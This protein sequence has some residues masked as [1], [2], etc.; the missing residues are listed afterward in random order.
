MFSDKKFIFFLL[1]SVLVKIVRAR[2]SD[3]EVAV[4][5]LRRSEKKTGQRQS[6]L[7]MYRLEDQTRQGGDSTSTK[8][9]TQGDNDDTKIGA[10]IRRGN[11]GMDGAVDSY[12]RT[13]IGRRKRTQSTR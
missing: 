12:C 9:E 4:W 11:N 6:A 7:T 8:T 13:D 2:N 10:E 3:G 1:F 5:I